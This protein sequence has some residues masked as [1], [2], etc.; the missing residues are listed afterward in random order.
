MQIKYELDRV[1]DHWIVFASIVA[2]IIII[3]IVVL[4]E[5]L[6]EEPCLKGSMVLTIL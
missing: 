3:I 6:S 1:K 4:S 2:R 5:D